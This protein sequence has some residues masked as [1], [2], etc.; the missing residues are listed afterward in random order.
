MASAETTKL[1]GGVRQESPAMPPICLQLHNTMRHSPAPDRCRAGG[2]TYRRP[3][4]A[5]ESG[6]VFSAFHG[7]R[8]HHRS[9]ADEKNPR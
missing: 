6:M 9:K 3:S 8:I 4:S 5:C 7:V 2:K 1:T